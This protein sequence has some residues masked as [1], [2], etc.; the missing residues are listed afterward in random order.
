MHFFTF[1]GFQDL[2]SNYT[3]C[4]NEERTYLWSMSAESGVSRNPRHDVG[5]KAFAHYDAAIKILI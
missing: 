3:Y 1:L 2:E 5:A 4:D